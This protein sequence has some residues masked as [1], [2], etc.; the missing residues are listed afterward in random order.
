MMSVNKVYLT[1]ATTKMNAQYPIELFS[2]CELK[3]QN[4]AGLIGAALRT[5]S[6]WS[7]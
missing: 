7:N 2:K 6:R 1:I 4:N 5:W 3:T